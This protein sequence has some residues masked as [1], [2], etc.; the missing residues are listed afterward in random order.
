LFTAH[1][2]AD[3]KGFLDM[4]DNFYWDI[5]KPLSYNCLF[6]FIIGNR[7]AGKTYGSLKYGADKFIKEDKRGNIS[8]FLYVRRNKTELEKLTTARNGRLFNS[9][10]NEFPGH[11]LK[12]ESNVLWYD[13]KIMGYAQPLSTASI[14]KSDAFPFVDTII[15]DEFIIDNTGTYHYLKDE[16]RKFLDLYETVARMRDVRVFFLSN[17]VSIAN[18]YFDFFHLDKPYNGD[19][20]RFGQSKDILVQNVA[21]TQLIEAKKETRFGKLIAGSEYSDYAIDNQWLLDN[22]D[23]IENK[24]ARSEY[25]VTLRYKDNWIGVWLD[26]LQWIFYISN[27]VDLQFK[28]V[29]SVTTDDHKPNT[30][31]FSAGKKL[32]FLKGLIDAYDKGAVRYESLK[33]KSWFKDIMR[34]SR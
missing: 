31:L 3:G 8:Q 22:Q 18:P 4:V 7:G 10:K 34:M 33:L 17:A 25:F 26:R 11:T 13:D 29:Y 1:T 6:N 20:Q 27:D 23:F 5:R 32:G 2:T 30:L 16:V 14:L 28:H 12:A 15:F 19:I 24:T 9:V 21:N